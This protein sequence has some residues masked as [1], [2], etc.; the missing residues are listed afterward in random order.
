MWVI[1]LDNGRGHTEWYAT[2]TVRAQARRKEHAHKF[3]DR[4]EAERFAASC[5]S[6]SLQ[7]AFSG[8]YFD[9]DRGVWTLTATVESL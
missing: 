2:L 5:Q 6:E 8:I 7:S 1:K 9:Y 3:A 4:E